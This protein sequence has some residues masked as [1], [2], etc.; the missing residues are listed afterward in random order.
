MSCSVSLKL[1]PNV[2][3][4]SGDLVRKED[5]SRRLSSVRTIVIM[6]PMPTAQCPVLC[7][8]QWREYFECFFHDWVEEDQYRVT[9][10]IR[11][12]HSPN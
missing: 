3:T 6:V 8:V 7:P 11:C 10:L 2:T 1:L 12:G 4:Q 5:L 9:L